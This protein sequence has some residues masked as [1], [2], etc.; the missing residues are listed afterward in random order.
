MSLNLETTYLPYMMSISELLQGFLN[1]SG[2]N[3]GKDH[4]QDMLDDIYHAIKNDEIIMPAE[5]TG[6]VKENYMW[7]CAL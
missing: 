5:Q 6:L 2:T 7:K 4:D 3:G 1:V